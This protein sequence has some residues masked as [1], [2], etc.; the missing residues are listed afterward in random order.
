MAHSHHN[1]AGAC[2][3]PKVVQAPSCHGSCCGSHETKKL[4]QLAASVSTAAGVHTPIRIM[5]MDC[6]TE[7]A[8]LRKKLGNMP[9]VA[10]LEFNLLQR[11]LTVTHQAEVLDAVLAGIRSLG[12]T[13]EL[14]DSA[15]ATSQVAA[16]AT[17]WW[18]SR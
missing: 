15:A 1:H 7:E 9:G 10:G 12:F 5:Q 3:T 17:S 14:A 11:V 18:P 16:P 8:L 13:P 4:V 2:C 6:P